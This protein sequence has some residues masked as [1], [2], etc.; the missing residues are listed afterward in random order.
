MAAPP[1][2]DN[3]AFLP[4]FEHFSWIPRSGCSLELHDSVCDRQCATSLHLN[5]AL[6][7]SHRQIVWQQ[8][9]AQV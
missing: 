6:L 3:I 8:K 4:E 7:T 1:G 9:K 2:Q 5:L